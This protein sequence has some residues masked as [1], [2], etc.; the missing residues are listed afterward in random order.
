MSEHP[1]SSPM[2]LSYDRAKCLSPVPRLVHLILQQAVLDGAD[3][4]E[5]RL[6]SESSETGFQV[7][8]RTVTG[9][10]KL[11]PSPGSLFSPCMVVL[12][13]HASVP[14]YAKGCVTGK[15]TTVNPASEWRLESDDL[16]QRVLLSKA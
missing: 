10:S 9:E 3:Q 13:N 15:I 1:N 5:F 2:D 14:Y 16:E 11:A 8:V 4:I 7:A 12:C 6:V